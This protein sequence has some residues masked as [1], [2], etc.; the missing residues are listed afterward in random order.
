MMLCLSGSHSRKEDF[1]HQ[2]IFKF[3]TIAFCLNGFAA[4]SEKGSALD[5]AFG[6]S[7]IPSDNI[8]A[9]DSFQ[10]IRQSVYVGQSVDLESGMLRA[11]PKKLFTGTLN[12]QIA[13]EEENHSPRHVLKEEKLFAD[14][15]E[16]EQDDNLR[17]ADCMSRCYATQPKRDFDDIAFSGSHKIARKDDH[18]GEPIMRNN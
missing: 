4:A 18:S 15:C 8:E 3:L 2:S 9:A 5:G 17:I 6:V 14:E 13:F 16:S 12:T 10:P 1:M 11:E 7:F